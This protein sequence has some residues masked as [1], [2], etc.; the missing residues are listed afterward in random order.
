[1]R[2]RTSGILLHISSLPSD[3]GIGDLGPGARSFVDFLRQSG[4]RLWQILP[5]NPTAFGNSP[6]SSP[7]A[8]ACNPL[9]ISPELMLRDGYLD[10]SELYPIPD[11]PKDRVDYDLVAVYKNELFKKAYERFKSFGENE[12]F[13]RFTAENA[14]WLDDYALFMAI[15]SSQP[16]GSWS[17]WPHAIKFRDAAALDVCARELRDEVEKEKFLQFIFSRQWSELRY[18]CGE[19]GVSIL[20]DV[21]IYV[22]HDSADVWAHPH[23]FK[24]DENRDPC[25][26]AGVPPDYFSPTGQLWGNPLYDW[27]KL[28]EQGYGWWI[29]RMEHNLKYFDLV[30]IDHF[31]GFCA[32]W[33]IPAG[34]TTAERGNWSWVPAVDFFSALVQ[35]LPPSSIVAEDL[36]FIT[37]DVREVME[38]FGFPGMKLLVFAFGEGIAENPY[39]PHNHVHNCVVYTGTHDCNTVKGWFENELTEAD[40]K[41]LFAYLGRKLTSAE[42]AWEMIHVAMV[43]VADRVILPM[44]DV[45]ALDASARMNQPGVIGE[46]WQWRLAAEQIVPEL[47]ERL[48]GLTALCGR[49]QGY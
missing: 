48:G 45:L 20:G 2:Q 1:M 6:Y 37:D 49:A 36:G 31:R 19:R 22:T 32:A 39:I 44:Q 15:K 4:Q 12:E 40:K 16:S 26:V 34:D 43:S 38:R 23:L 21:A 13:V 46:N 33:E 18:Y 10:N 3:F 11:F 29:Q 41:R 8:F 24:L 28:K 27:D 14:Y 30:R 9:F 35:K 17:D 47:S 5:L 7:S 42:I 25:L